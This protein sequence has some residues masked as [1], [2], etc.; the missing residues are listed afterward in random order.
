MIKRLLLALILFLSFSGIVF[1]S[2]DKDFEQLKKRAEQGDI[3][4]QCDLASVCYIGKGV[5][6]N[7]AKAL[8][9][10]KK[11]AEKGHPVAQFGLG[12]MHSE[13]EG[14]PQNYIEGYVWLSMAS[15]KGIKD[16]KQYLPIVGSKMMPEQITEAKKKAAVLSEKISRNLLRSARMREGVTV[17]K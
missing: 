3:N 13:G 6:Q 1:S 7:Y 15:A 4:A 12:V 8:K 17:S 14:V 2:E 9:W 16:A 10:Y 5:P 11:A